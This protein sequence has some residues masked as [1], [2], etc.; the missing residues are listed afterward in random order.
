MT[1][2]LSIWIESTFGLRQEDGSGRL[3]RAR[4]RSITG[5]DS[6]AGELSR[7][8]E[9]PESCCVEALQ[10]DLLGG[11]RC[12]PNSDTG[13][14]PFA[15]RLHQFISRGDTVYASLEP[16]SDRHIT[17][18]GQQF[19]PGDRTKILLPLAFCRECGQEY[20]C[21]RVSKDQESRIK[22][23]TQRELSD[24]FSDD[25]SE[26][27]FLHIS[28]D[29]PWPTD[30]QAVQDRLPDDW[31]EEHRGT[32]RVRPNRR[33]DFPQPVRVATDGHEA[34]NGLDCHYVSAP[35]RFCLQ[36]GVSYG[37]ANR[38]ISPS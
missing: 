16:E 25:D 18:Q 32:I 19:V 29:N 20:Y 30:P 35:F 14:P 23:F 5:I 27:G 3:I 31:L 38:R 7:V 37:P 8:I 11:Y 15:F 17:L 21:V 6:A 26:A 22:T 24:R 34:E 9:V 33:G 28:S 4:P 1:D 2:P 36:C 12:E 13:F 10:E